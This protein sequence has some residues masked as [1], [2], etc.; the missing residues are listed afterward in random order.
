MVLD[1]EQAKFMGKIMR[2]PSTFGDLKFEDE[3]GRN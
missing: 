1:A 3:K 2:D